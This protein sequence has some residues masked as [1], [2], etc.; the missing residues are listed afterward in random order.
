MIKYTSGLAVG[1]NEDNVHSMLTT[2]N[3]PI[4]DIYQLDKC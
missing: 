1:T 2:I 3:G 4:P